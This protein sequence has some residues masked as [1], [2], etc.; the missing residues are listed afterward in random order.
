[1]AAATP[2]RPAQDLIQAGS[3]YLGEFRDQAAYFIA[4]ERD[5]LILPAPMPLIQPR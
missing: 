3:A 5:E 2:C 4:A 1:L